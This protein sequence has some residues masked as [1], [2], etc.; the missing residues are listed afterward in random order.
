MKIVIEFN[1]SI[2]CLWEIMSVYA[3]KRAR[4]KNVLTYFKPVY[5]FS[6]RY[7]RIMFGSSSTSMF[8]NALFVCYYF[9]FTFHVET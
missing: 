2:G 8:V 7:Q 4:C 3:V 9:V 5:I 1:V 6:K